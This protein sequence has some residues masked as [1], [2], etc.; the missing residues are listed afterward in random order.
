MIPKY[1]STLYDVP[2]LSYSLLSKK[3]GRDVLHQSNNIHNLVY[4]GRIQ[5]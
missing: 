4:F 5:I 3:W 1:D 2:E